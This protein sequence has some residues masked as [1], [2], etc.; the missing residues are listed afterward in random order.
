MPERR[1]Y[2]WRQPPRIHDRAYARPGTTA[3]SASALLV[4]TGLIGHA[5][6]TISGSDTLMALPG[7]LKIWLGVFLIVGGALALAGLLRAWHDLARGWRI[8]SAGWILQV[9]AWAGL[10]GLL[11]YLVPFATITWPLTF[12]ATMTAIL[13]MRALTHIERE[14]RRLIADHGATQQESQ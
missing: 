12:A 8:E 10:T 9:G 1:F 14:A 11:A 7:W 2:T 3:I 5:T 13:R 4:G 6:G